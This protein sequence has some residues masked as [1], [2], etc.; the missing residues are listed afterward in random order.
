M[1]SLV[2]HY[3]KQLNAGG[4]LGILID[5]KSIKLKFT[6]E[7]NPSEETKTELERMVPPAMV[8]Q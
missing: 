4:S 2:S 5:K 6:A 3:R 7:F 8:G 1:P